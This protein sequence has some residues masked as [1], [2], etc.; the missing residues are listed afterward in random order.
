[1][2]STAESECADAAE[3]E[4]A[5][6]ACAEPGAELGDTLLR[7]VSLSSGKGNLVHIF[8]SFPTICGILTSLTICSLAII[9]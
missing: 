7:N 5:G 2:L 3:S 4:C 1:M 8:P 9:S 6:D